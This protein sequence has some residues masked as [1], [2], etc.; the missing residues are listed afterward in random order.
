LKRQVEEGEEEMARVT[1]QKR[2][3][4]RD[5]EEQTEVADSAQR[6]LDQLR[7][8]MRI[9]TGT[10]GI[11]SGRTSARPSYVPGSAVSEEAAAEEPPTETKEQ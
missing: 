3:L 7:S 4:Q 2:K 5:V 11:R 9:A 1:A 8:K 10:A 6:E